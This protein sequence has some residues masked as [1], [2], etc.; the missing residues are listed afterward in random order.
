MKPPYVAVDELDAGGQVMLHGFED[1]WMTPLEATC[2]A[3][4]ETSGYPHLLSFFPLHAFPS[5]QVAGLKPT[6][7]FNRITVSD[8]EFT[9]Y[10]G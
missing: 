8:G 2:K 4:G 5:S 7:N 6:S 9:R 3:L 10:H 1:P